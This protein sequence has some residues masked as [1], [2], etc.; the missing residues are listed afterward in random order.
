VDD[1]ISRQPSMLLR[2]LGVSDEKQA[3]QAHAELAQD[4]FEFL[5]GLEQGA[6]WPAY[7]GQLESQRLGVDVPEGWVPATFLVAEAG[8][9]IVGR[10]SIRHKLNA[11]FAE[12]GGH[13]GY[14]V[15]PGFRRRGYATTILGQSLAVASSIGL[16]RVLVTCDDD[17]VGSANVIESCG[18]VLENVVAGRDGSVPLRRYWVEI[19]A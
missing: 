12:V 1:K 14:G 18:G 19:G 8:G 4:G 5:F 7:C 3:L 15:R 11:Y 2:P 9:Q 13:I 10:V 16:E 17:N 6:P